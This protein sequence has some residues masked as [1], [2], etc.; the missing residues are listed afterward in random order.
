VAEGGRLNR[1]RRDA[2][3]GTAERPGNSAGAG[4]TPTATLRLYAA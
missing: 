3:A 1:R 4:A 2:P